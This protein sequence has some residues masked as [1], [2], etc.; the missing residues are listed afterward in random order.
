VGSAPRNAAKSQADQQSSV[1]PRFKRFVRLAFAAFNW[2][3][4]RDQ[5]FRLYFA[6]GHP[7]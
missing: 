7:P 3:C 5:R 6:K 1:L 4:S 2:Q